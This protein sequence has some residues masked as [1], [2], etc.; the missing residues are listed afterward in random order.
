M[1]TNSNFQKISSLFLLVYIFLFGLILIN[2]INVSG[3]ECVSGAGEYCLLE[4]LPLTDNNTTVEKTNIGTY[5]PQFIRLI[6]ALAG[7]LAVIMLIFAGFQYITS[8]GF[9]KKS[10]AREKINSALLGLL[11]IIGSYSI[12]YTINPKTL[13]LDLSIMKAVPEGEALQNSIPRTTTLPE[14]LESGGGTSGGSSGGTGVLLC[15]RDQW[16]TIA[17]TNNEYYEARPAP[18]LQK[19]I[20]CIQ[21]NTAGRNLGSIYTIDQSNPVCNYTRGQTTCSTRCSH[22][23]N[24][25]HYGGDNGSQGALAVD[26]GNEVNGDAIIAAAKSCGSGSAR[27]EDSSGNTVACK[28]GSGA[29][30]VHVNAAS[31]N[32]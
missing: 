6:I 10:N 23:Q 1:K 19:L 2:P 8:D 20:S 3:A 26:F 28:P 29:T 16:P 31:C 14:N 17:K 13:T 18:E 25:C 22:S 5:I 15:S 24:S 12:L 7:A 27:C 9:G 4:P 30:H 11:L 21:Q 32:K